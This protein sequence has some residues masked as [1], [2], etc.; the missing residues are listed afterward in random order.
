MHCVNGYISKGNYSHIFRFTSLLKLFEPGRLFCPHKLDEYTCQL[1]DAILSLFLSFS[2]VLRIKHYLSSANSMYP[3]QTLIGL[4]C[5][6]MSVLWDA[7]LK[8]V[9]VALIVK[10]TIRP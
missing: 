6:L 10:K 8:W 3:D 1:K 7:S 5:F 2:S 9:N 4:Q